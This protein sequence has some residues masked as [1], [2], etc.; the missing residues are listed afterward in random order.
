MQAHSHLCM[1]THASMARENSSFED[2]YIHVFLLFLKKVE[3]SAEFEKQ[4]P[5]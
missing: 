4:A 1:R 2:A 3:N 5:V